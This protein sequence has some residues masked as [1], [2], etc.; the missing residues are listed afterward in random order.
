[1]REGWLCRDNAVKLSNCKKTCGN[2]F[3]EEYLGEECDDANDIDEDGCTKCI[4]DSGWQCTGGSI[5]TYDT[6]C[7]KPIV[8]IS[9]IT[10]KN[11]V[12]IK[13]DQPMQIF[14]PNDTDF[15]ISLKSNNG[16]VTY[17]YSVE[18][19][20]LNA[21]TLN[22]YFDV[23]NIAGSKKENLTIEFV[24]T[25]WKSQCGATLFN[26]QVWGHPFKYT[27]EHWL[28]KVLGE[29][30][31]KSMGVTILAQ[32]VVMMFTVGQTALFWGM[33]NNV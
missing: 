3:R 28:T 6:C 16:K 1:M 30:I 14:E 4:V 23:L 7:K 13:F 29:I 25:R 22:L 17:K 33:I 26:F 19:E 21:N 9:N 12:I 11:K 5:E 10:E 32:F 18:Y 20:F 2:G 8:S 27:K 15:N 31:E 24:S